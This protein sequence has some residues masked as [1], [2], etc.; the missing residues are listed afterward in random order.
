MQHSAHTCRRAVLRWTVGRQLL[1]PAARRSIL[2][3][4]THL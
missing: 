4:P 2:L 1:H 3:T